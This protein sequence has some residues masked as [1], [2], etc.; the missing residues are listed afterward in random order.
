MQWSWV[1]RAV[2]GG[3]LLTA[4]GAMGQESE[5]CQM[6]HAEA[7]F[8]KGNAD[9]ASLVVTQATLAG[10]VHGA[11]GLRCGMCHQGMAVF[12]HPEDATPLDC[13]A[14]H[15]DIG[16]QY[17]KSL[18]GYAH[19]RGNPRAPTCVSCHGVHDVRSSADPSSPTHKV[20]L[21]A[22]C[23][24]C[25]GEAG[26]LTD[27][28]VKLPQSFTDYAQSVHG[29]GTERGIAAAASCA[30]CHGVHE[31][32]GAADPQSRI[33]PRNVASTCG[34]CH[35][36]MQLAY[37]RSIH[38]RALQAG[39][40]DSPTCT[41]CHGEHHILS[42]RDPEAKTYAARLAHETCGTCHEDPVIV[43]KY[44]LQGGVVESYVDS[45]HGWATRHDYASAASCVDCHTAHLVLP[46]ADS[47]STV[48][49]ANVVST[50]RQCHPNADSE[51]AA[52]YTHATASIARNPVNRWIRNIYVA[53]ILLFIGGMIVHNLII[54]NYYMMKRRREIETAQWV[55]RFDKSQVVQHLLLTVT[56]VTLVVTGF[57]LRFP[58]AWWVAGLRAIGM[59]EPVRLNLHRIAA[60]G[61]IVASLWHAYYVLLTRRGKAEFRALWVSWRDVKEFIQNLRYHTFRSDRKVR[62]GRFDYSQKAEYWAL[63][64]GTVI[65]AITGVILWF[66]AATTRLL[67]AVTVSAAQTI[68][69]Y[70]AWLAT[71]A[72]LVWHFFFV[73]FHPEEYPMS[74]TWLTGKMSRESAE[75]HH[76]RWLEEEEPATADRE[77]RGTAPVA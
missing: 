60:V 51:F 68:H 14:C 26:L 58:D 23:A 22:T 76:P 16:A 3:A 37:D 64:W 1:G 27:Q 8:F 35:P 75:E 61:L 54:M 38:G 77:T 71:L 9:S 73:I 15:E 52:S 44:N 20:R 7:S 11:A 49:P 46:Q 31:L 74:W 17:V 6:C 5:P 43:A 62:F 65:M 4:G 25:H 70:E 13:G 56:F 66:P 59:T 36:D 67:P 72:I 33:N 28:I 32:L 48:A 45:Y 69:Y 19:E 53:V 29:M 47:A 41:D 57:A 24:R 10:S 50:C 39:V 21:P 34:Q 42:P 30:D 12:P 40:T 2:I 55:L 18:H 63:I